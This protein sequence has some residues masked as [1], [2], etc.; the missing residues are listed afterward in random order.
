M[1]LVKCVLGEPGKENR[2]AKEAMDL[3]VL[4][5]VQGFS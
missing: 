2:A 1:N 3:A 4:P 5:E